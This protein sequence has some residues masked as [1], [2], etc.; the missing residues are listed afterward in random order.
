MDK[1]KVIERANSMYESTGEIDIVELCSLLGIDVYGDDESSI[2]AKIS[3]S[4]KKNFEITFNS[5]HQ[6][7]RVRFS[8]A[9]TR[10]DVK[11]I[12]PYSGIS[13]SKNGASHHCNADLAIMRAIPTAI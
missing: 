5:K 6:L 13:A 12:A 8:I 11:I 4:D 2:N 1:E 10:A 7:T 3:V 9:H